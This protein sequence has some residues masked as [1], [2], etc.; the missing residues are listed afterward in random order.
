MLHNEHM[1]VFYCSGTTGLKGPLYRNH[2]YYEF[3]L[4]PLKGWRK[5]NPQ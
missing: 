2:I 3:D 4:L 1:K 5:K